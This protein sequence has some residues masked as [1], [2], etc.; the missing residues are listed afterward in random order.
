MNMDTRTYQ[1]YVK[2]RAPKS[3]CIK[4]CIWAFLVGGVI[5]TAGQVLNFLY[6]TYVFTDEKDAGTLTSITLVLLAVLLTGAGVFDRIAKRAGGGTL[7]PI[8]GFANA[9]ASPAIDAKS[10]GFILGVGAKIFTVAGP[11]I[12][13]GTSASVIW[14]VIYWV[15][16]RL[17]WM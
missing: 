5:C 10:E 17:G 15:C 8:T 3:P 4:N 11:V 7:L 1:R 12:L 2:A 16:K 6:R 9:V 14:G 13:Y